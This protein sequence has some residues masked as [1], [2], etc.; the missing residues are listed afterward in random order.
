MIER[1][2]QLTAS[3]PKRTRRFGTKGGLQAFAAIH[4]KVCSA[5]EADYHVAKLNVRSARLNQP[6]V[7]SSMDIS[8]QVIPPWS[9]VDGCR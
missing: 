7:Q 8:C 9:E 2:V 6:A 5:D 3:S 1:S 4:F